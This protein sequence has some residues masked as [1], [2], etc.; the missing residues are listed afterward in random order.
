[1]LIAWRGADTGAPAR[2]DVGVA[3]A[4]A[5][6]EGRPVGG[7]D[8]LA[9]VMYN[10]WGQYQ[11]ALARAD[12]AYE[13]DDL[14]VFGFTL[15][16]IVEAG[17]R[18]GDL[19][20]AAGAL[21]RLEERA[22]A[23]GTDWALGVLARSRALLADGKAADALYR[24]AVERLGRGRVAVHLART[25]LVYGEWLRR[26]GRRR[27]AREHLRTAYE[28]LAGFGATAFAERTRR[29]LVATG[30]TV[31]RRAAGAPEVLTAQEA[32]I[33]RLAGAGKTNPEIG[34]ELFISPRTVEWHLS[35]VF[36]KLA[37]DSRSKL[38]AALTGS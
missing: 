15:L 26:E 1:L 4:L 12:R 29:E 16:E 27:D 31:S 37:I 30:E 24:E 34:A 14:G 35:K 20:A 13:H 11:A 5:R 32:Q 8:Y 33:A 28:M 19:D 38:S 9:T 7:A 17:V 6:G 36:T 18:A 22:T 2:L 10:G 3:A 21:R 25:H 23:A